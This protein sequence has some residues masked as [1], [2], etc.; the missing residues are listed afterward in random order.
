[1]FYVAVE[2]SPDGDELPRD[3][4][5]FEVA[6]RDSAAAFRMGSCGVS[7]VCGLPR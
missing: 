3:F 7:S 1:M 2:R 4:N 6:A 5:D